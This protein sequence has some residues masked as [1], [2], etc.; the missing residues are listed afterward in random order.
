MQRGKPE[1]VDENKNKIMDTRL[2]EGQEC[3][4]N[5]QIANDTKFRIPTRVVDAIMIFKREPNLNL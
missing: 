5:T 4:R 1:Y 2:T 3:E